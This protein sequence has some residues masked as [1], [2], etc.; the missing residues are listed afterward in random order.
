MRPG[1]KSC[2][3][4]VSC[5]PANNAA[6]LSALESVLNEFHRQTISYCYWKSSRRIQAVFEG[7]GD[8]DLLIARGDQHRAQAILLKSGFKLFPS[9]WYRDH[10]AV[11]SFLGYDESSGKLIHLHLHFRLI[12]GEPL[13]KNYRIPWEPVLLDRAVLHESYPIRILDGASEALLLVMRV[14]LELRRV[15]LVVLQGW[16]RL[17]NKFELDRAFLIEQVTPGALRAIA[18]RLLDDESAELV[19]QAFYC[20]QPLHD[21]RHIFRRL[22]KC[23]AVHRSYNSSEV[24]ARSLG[25]TLLCIGGNLN[26]QLLIFPRPWSRRAPGGGCIIAFVGVDG[27]GKSTLVSVI[28]EWL[29]GK[30][31][32]MSTYFGTGDGK[33]SFWLWPFKRMMPL[34]TWVL[35]HKPKP[36]CASH[37]PASGP[38]PGLIY[39]VLLTVWALMVALD[40]WKKL[41]AARR[42]TNRGLIVLADRF[43]QDQILGFND[44][45][46]LRRL[47]WVPAWLVGL[48][49]RAYSLARR[50]P[51]DLV[52]KLV[53]RQETTAR[54]EPGMDPIVIRERIAALQ[55]LNF[56]GARVALVNAEQ[57]LAEVIRAVKREVWNLI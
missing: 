14:C 25:R 45:P 20:K 27:S 5:R 10:P 23:V 56:A 16:K 19:A 48:E 42:S 6:P 54:R 44:G 35:S 17:V 30:V 26:K 3:T 21:Q 1:D 18:T 13:L 37:G 29:G 36:K 39:S 4:I 38:N 15:D 53:V 9:V 41:I 51:P 50:V 43:P 57:P 46:L 11:V 22:R 31:D 49:A 24:R 40:K 7:E 32:V 12:I 28:K 52:I 55:Q 47:R 33:P 8:V 2:E 34:F